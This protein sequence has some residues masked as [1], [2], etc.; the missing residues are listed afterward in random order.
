VRLGGPELIEAGATLWIDCA[1]EPASLELLREKLGLHPLALEDCSHEGQRAKVEEYPGSLFVVL[2]RVARAEGRA[3]GLAITEVNSFLLEK[4]LVTVHR[5]PVA[6]VDA[7][8]EK[9]RA[10]PALLARGPD[11]AFYLVADALTDAHFQLS[12]DLTLHID[13]VAMEAATGK[14]DRTRLRRILAARRTHAQLR[15]VF[16]SHRDA[17][18]SLSKPFAARVSERTSLYF[19]DVHDH[20]V[21]ITEEID[22]GRDLLSSAMDAHLAVESNRMNEVMKRLAVVS[23]IF[24]PLNFVTSFFGMNVPLGDGQRDL[25]FVLAVVTLLPLGLLL[26]FRARRWL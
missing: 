2:H 5:R 9:A 7:I 19:R 13:E 20:L 4:T 26:W 3:A 17:L 1:P 10:D 11:F 6:E 22:V 15:R 25:F 16:G 18:A 23:T 21:R 8:F 12:D 24:L 14:D